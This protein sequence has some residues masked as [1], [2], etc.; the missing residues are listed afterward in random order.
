MLKEV[1]ETLLHVAK[2]K[3]GLADK[4]EDF[5]KIVFSQQ[6]KQCVEANVAGIVGLGRMGKST[7][8]KKMSIVSLDSL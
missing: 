1:L 2:Y 8:T 6:E 4:F 5:E 3:I 7:L